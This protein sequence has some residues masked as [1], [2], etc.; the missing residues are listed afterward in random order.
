MTGSS[1]GVPHMST[2]FSFPNPVNEVAA[3]TVATGVVIMAVAA[4]AFRQYWLLIPLAYG[5]VARVLTGPKLSP[6]GQIATKVVA[7]RLSDRAR[8]VPAPPRRFPQATGPPLPL[9]ALILYSVFATIGA[10]RS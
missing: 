7:P 9:P 6:L 10:P 3:R 5:F 8:M 1:R 4:L 2:V